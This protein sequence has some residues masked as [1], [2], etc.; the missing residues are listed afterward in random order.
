[1]LIIEK[2]PVTPYT[3]IFEIVVIASRF[4]RGKIMA[5]CIRNCELG[6]SPARL[7]FQS[8]S[9]FYDDKKSLSLS[10]DRVTKILF[11]LANVSN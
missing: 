5:E 6:E 7:R 10:P 3:L 9:F 1:M 11:A 2:N 8:L 4:M